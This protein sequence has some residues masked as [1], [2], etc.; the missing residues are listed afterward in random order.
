MSTASEPQP[1]PA[2]PTPTLFYRRPL[3]VIVAGA[4][5]A[6][7]ILGGFATAALLS[8]KPSLHVAV[9]AMTRP[10]ATKKPTAK[11]RLGPPRRPLRRSHRRFPWRPLLPR[12]P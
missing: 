5:V 2:E 9:A 10:T 4:I 6:V 1:E 12:P 8:A 7:L 3:V 11:P